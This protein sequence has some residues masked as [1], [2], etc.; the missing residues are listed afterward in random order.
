M[1]CYDA[2]AIPII[3]LRRRRPLKRFVVRLHEPGGP[4]VPLFST[5]S[6]IGVKRLPYDMSLQIMLPE[7]DEEAANLPGFFASSMWRW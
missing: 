5:T 3:L 7:T 1:G 4:R 6:I 2:R